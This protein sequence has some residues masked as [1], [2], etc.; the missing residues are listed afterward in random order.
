M[1]KMLM[2][3]FCGWFWFMNNNE[4]D[5]KISEIS[6]QRRKYVFFCIPKNSNVHVPHIKDYF[7][8]RLVIVGKFGTSYCVYTFM[9][10]DW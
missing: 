9:M 1:P 5:L 6:I 8:D 3:S 10:S 7:S 2:L 4:Y